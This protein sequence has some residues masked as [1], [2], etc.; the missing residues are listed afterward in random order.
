MPPKTCNWGVY[1]VRAYEGLLLPPKSRRHGACAGMAPLMPVRFATEQ[2]VDMDVETLAISCACS[3]AEFQRQS[4]QAQ[5]KMTQ[6]LDSI[7]S[8]APGLT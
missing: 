3:V 4:W 5:D 8:S 2:P 6:L 7:A 1:D